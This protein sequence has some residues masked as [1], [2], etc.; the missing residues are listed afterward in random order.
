MTRHIVFVS[1]LHMYGALAF[2]V[3]I[4]KRNLF[5]LIIVGMESSDETRVIEFSLTTC[6]AS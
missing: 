1:S 2:R 6:I 5:V 3:Q 4:E